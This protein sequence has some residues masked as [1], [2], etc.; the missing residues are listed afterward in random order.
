MS[1]ENFRAAAKGLGQYDPA[2]NELLVSEGGEIHRFSC[3]K[4]LFRHTPPS[5]SEIVIP[6]APDAT[7]QEF[8]RSFAMLIDL[9]KQ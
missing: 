1:L 5:R 7:V 8:R 3:G 6:I 2:N 4:G 9:S